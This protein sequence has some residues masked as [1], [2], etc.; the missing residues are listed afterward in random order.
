M[1][2]AVPEVNPEKCEGC[3][4]CVKLCPGQA[5]ALV[6]GKATVVRPE[7]CDYCAECEAFCPSSA[8]RCPFE[9]VIERP[10]K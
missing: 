2:L 5:V 3:G 8:V 1:G 6:L 9:I 10:E 4:D 7:N